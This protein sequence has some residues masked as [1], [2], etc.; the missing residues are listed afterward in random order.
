MLS[1]DVNVFDEIYNAEKKIADLRNFQIWK[2]Q[3]K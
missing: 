3:S 1:G 2:C